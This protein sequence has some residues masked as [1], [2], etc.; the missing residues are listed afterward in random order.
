MDDSDKVLVVPAETQMEVD[1]RL[2]SKKKIL[3]KSKKIKK[4]EK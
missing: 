3:K 4:K 2:A 1:R